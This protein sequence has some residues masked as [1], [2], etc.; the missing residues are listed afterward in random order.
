MVEVYAERERVE[1]E[2]RAYLKK[3]VSFFKDETLEAFRGRVE[4][5]EL[6]SYYYDTEEDKETE[7]IGICSRCQ[8]KTCARDTGEIQRR[9]T[10][11]KERGY[12]LGRV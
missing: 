11:T 5:K 10:T 3:D 8:R 1:R 6:S 9:E 2:M 4:R 7:C 12:E